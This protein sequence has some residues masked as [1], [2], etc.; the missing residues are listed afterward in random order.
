[1]FKHQCHTCRS[2]LNKVL[3]R[4]TMEEFDKIMV[5]IREDRH[6]KIFKR[7][8][9]KLDWLMSKEEHVN[10]GGCSNPNMQRYMYHS[11]T[12]NH[13]GNRYMYQSG[14]SNSSRTSSITPETG[15]TSEN[16]SNSRA[17]SSTTTLVKPDSKWVINLSKKPLIEPQVKLLAHGPN[18]AVIPI[19]PPI[20]EYITAVEKTCQSLTQ[21]EADEMRAEIKAAIMRSHPPT[22]HH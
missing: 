11:S 4:E 22:Q 17:T 1:M 20:G 12:D 8:E 10:R 13:R 9:A 6:Q 5:K 16:S 21:G 15:T 18:Y 14:T 3:D 7:Q 2:D 19:N